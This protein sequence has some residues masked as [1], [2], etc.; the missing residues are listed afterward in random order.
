MNNIEKYQ[1][2]I[3]ENEKKCKV[4]SYPRSP[5][6]AAQSTCWNSCENVRQQ[7]VSSQLASSKYMNK[8][9]LFC[10]KYARFYCP[11][12][13]FSLTNSGHFSTGCT[14]GNTINTFYSPP[15][16]DADYIRNKTKHSSKYETILERD[17]DNDLNNEAIV[18]NEKEKFIYHFDPNYPKS[19]QEV[20]SLHEF[21][22][23]DAL[24]KEGIPEKI[25][26]KLNPDLSLPK[27]KLSVPK[28]VFRNVTNLVERVYKGFKNTQDLRDITFAQFSMFI[29]SFIAICNI[30]FS[31]KF[32]NYC[33]EHEV[34]LPR[35]HKNIDIQKPF[36]TK[37]IRADCKTLSKHLMQETINQ[38][39]VQLKYHK[40]KFNG[41]CF[42]SCLRST[43]KNRLALYQLLIRLRNTVAFVMSC[44]HREKVNKV[45]QNT[46]H[47][48]VNV[49]NLLDIALEESAGVV[50]GCNIQHCPL[51]YWDYRAFTLEWINPKLK[52]NIEVS[53]DDN[54]TIVEDVKRVWEGFL[55]NVTK[56]KAI[57]PGKKHI[58]NNWR[59]NWNRF[60][61]GFRWGQ[62]ISNQHDL[63]CNLQYIDQSVHIPWQKPAVTLPARSTPD[64]EIFLATLKMA[65]TAEMSTA[66][67]D[68]QLNVE[69]S[70]FTQELLQDFLDS[71]NY[72]VVSS[73]KTNRCLLMKNEDYFA[74][75]ERFLT[76]NND[77]LLLSRDPN[78][79]ILDK[80]NS[81]INAIKKANHTFRKGDLNKL[82]KYTSHPARLSFVVKDHK[83][84]DEMGFH[85]FR[86]LAN[87]NGSAL[88]SLDW[89]FA[90]IVNQAVRLVDYHI[91]N[92]QQVLETMP[93]INNI[94]IPEGYQR[95]I[96]SLDVVSLYPTVPTF[97][98][99]NLVFRFIKEHTEINTFGIP[100]PIIREI[101]NVLINNYNIEFN[102]RI[103]KQTKGV[104]MGA[105]FSCAFSIAFMH[106][107]ESKLVKTWFD[108]DILPNTNL[109]YYGRYIDDVLIIFDEK[110]EGD[111]SNNIL[112][113]FNKMHRNIKFTLEQ[114][115]EEGGLAFLDMQL[116]VNHLNRVCTKWYMKPQH[117]ENFIKG[118][119][120]MPEN[121]KRNTLIERFRAVMVRSS[122]PNSA[123]AGIIKLINIMIKNKHPIFKIMGALRQAYN[124]N[125]R[126]ITTPYTSQEGLIY[127][128]DW[129][130]SKQNNF[131]NSLKD[132]E[133][134]KSILKI[135]YLGE[136]LK[137]TV[138]D[139]IKKFGRSGQIRV[140]YS[141]NQ[142]LKF[143]KPQDNNRVP[144]ET[145]DFCE[146]CTHI[147]GGGQLPLRIKDCHLQVA[148]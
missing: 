5:D 52:D 35:F 130:H 63:A 3:D 90:K 55:T 17:I 57:T 62:N 127:S 110:L 87:I 21:D 7:N 96:I 135:P 51:F 16:F 97:D 4:W 83:P 82:I 67:Q 41:Y 107:I 103:Y 136:N 70:L 27:L 61:Y 8:Q 146:I 50:T 148:V 144:E 24:I 140:V 66:W 128:F 105:R 88:D 68:F 22:N 75:G 92:S 13:K 72:R 111:N 59:D 80:A 33:I 47:V 117:S 131:D 143:L 101:L 56:S 6:D 142:R 98:A 14:G 45:L 106:L 126:S 118:D 49:N 112:E 109:I 44:K 20:V 74:R 76:E 73:D 53:T 93:K 23:R 19:L 134:I 2:C 114:V 147:E 102:G 137:H 94:P 141:S 139:V 132:F 95:R 26:N 138:N 125:E 18:Q 42:E 115:D 113:A 77:Y 119:E 12:A 31:N 40:T 58:M 48:C 78:K 123:R 81:L 15:H 84:Q 36:R 64:A 1:I 116:Y 86:P 69:D 129:R 99:A 25:I 79:V 85:P 38:N 133:P 124:K 10:I 71:N 121:V 39:N 46:T 108:G 65:I 28:F 100:Y 104:A 120:F 54:A 60:L 11:A 30:T 34:I 145:R 29:R 91:W 9:C 32:L 43:P 122:E 89:I 37:L